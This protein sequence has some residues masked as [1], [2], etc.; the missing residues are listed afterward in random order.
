MYSPYSWSFLPCYI[1]IL[2]PETLQWKTSNFLMFTFNLL[3]DSRLYPTRRERLLLNILDLLLA[4]CY[5]FQS[6]MT[7]QWCEQNLQLAKSSRCLLIQYP[8]SLLRCEVCRRSR[9]LQQ[10]FFLAFSCQFFKFRN[11]TCSYL[12]LLAEA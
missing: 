7:R 8:R 10:Y 3:L 11:F 1:N 9:C 12:H 6:K 5:R 4:V 2:P